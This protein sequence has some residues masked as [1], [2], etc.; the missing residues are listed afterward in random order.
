M[1][2]EPCPG[3]YTPKTIET[4]ESLW[5]C[6]CDS[7]L[8]DLLLCSDDQDTIF[9][10]VRVSSSLTY[11]TVLRPVYVVAKILQSCDSLVYSYIVAIVY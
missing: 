9:I 5:G 4:R 10:R 3:G 1:Q 6:L 11:N 7:Q 2:L 8:D